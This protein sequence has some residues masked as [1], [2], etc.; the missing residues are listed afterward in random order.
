MVRVPP[1]D[2]AAE[3]STLGSMLL[4][5]EAITI[6]AGM[7]KG[8][9]FYTPNHTEIFNVILALVSKG[10]PVDA[11]TVSAEL[12]R[13]GMSKKI[14]GTYLVT[15]TEHTP[16]AINVGAYARVV[17]DKARQRKIIAA[18]Q[19]FI[20]LGMTEASC[21]EDVDALLGQA[22]SLF[23]ELGEPS[24]HGLG[25]D[26]LVQ[27]W[28]SWQ[29]TE[30]G[31]VPTPW[32]ELN[33]MLNGGCHHGQ[34]IIIGGRPGDGKSNAG[35]NIVLG[36]AEVGYRA[37]AFSVE[38]DD[39]EVCSRL[40]AAGSWSEQS[41]IIAR[42][43]KPETMERVEDYIE[44][45]RGMPLELVDQ[46][47][48]TVEQIV[49]HCRM[50]RPEIIFVDYAQLIS[51]TNNKVSRE[52]QVAHI[53]RSLKVA[54]KHLQM[55]VVVAAQLNRGPADGSRV[56]VISDLRESG[57]AEQD[58]DVV[59]LLHRQTDVPGTVTIICGKNRNGPTGTV[60]LTFR[61]ELARIG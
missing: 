31:I 24:R 57:A 37:T 22:D 35:L 46:A 34:M 53:T 6:A 15:L 41:E 51:A 11:I 56:P 3:Q 59:L 2:I 33:C 29:K 58:A 25:W 9:H 17:Y 50:R 7:L 12:G 48:I 60:V 13:R 4:S 19:R 47:Y 5:R 42:R 21:T 55:V 28:R 18:G 1:S 14:D 27:K 38:M 32:E 54:A 52:Q 30:G 39:V 8:E 40:L 20:E 26:D 10:E 23:K 36:A 16:S 49:A 44:G 43:M 61:G 45:H